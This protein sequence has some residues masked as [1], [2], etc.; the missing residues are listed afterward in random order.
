MF[1]K[2]GR[3]STTLDNGQVVLSEPSVL[4]VNCELRRIL[5]QLKISYGVFHYNVT[6]WHFLN[7]FQLPTLFI[8]NCCYKISKTTL[9][10]TSPQAQ[11][12]ELPLGLSTCWYESAQIIFLKGF[13]FLSCITN[14]N[15]TNNINL[16]IFCFFFYSIR[17]VADGSR[18]QR[19]R[20]PRRRNSL[21]GG[22]DWKGQRRGQESDGFGEHF[23]QLTH[24][25]NC[26]ILE[27]YSNNF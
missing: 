6:F 18:G 10:P 20:S 14:F 5:I 17:L 13:S 25:Y 19:S 16:F 9:P 15:E 3:I 2:E 8:I 4:P 22:C 7:L 26:L 27:M 23:F 12:L 24:V 1:S 21:F 11:F